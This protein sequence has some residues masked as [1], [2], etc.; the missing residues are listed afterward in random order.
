MSRKSCLP[1]ALLAA[2]IAFL[3]PLTAAPAAAQVDPA[4]FVNAFEGAMGQHK[5]FRR[6]GA[7]GVCAVGEFVGNADGRNLS[8][9]S[10]FSGRA[11]PVVLRFSVGGANPKAPDNAKSVR[12]MAVAFDLPNSET[13]QMANISTPVF[14]A[15]TPE[16]F[17]ALLES[18]AVDPQTRA[19]DPAKVKAFND[20]NPEV[21][22]QGRYLAGQPVPA[23]Y[24]MVNY[25]GVNSFVFVNDKG[26]RRHAKWVFE[27]AAGTM[28]LS[29]EEAKAKPADFL[30]DELRQRVAQGAV[31]F[32]F[33]LQLAEPGDNVT[34][35]V[36]PLPADRRKV[37]VGQLLVR[38]VEAADGGACANMTFN[39]TALP[40]GVEASADPI[41]LGRAAPYA[42]SL[43]RRLTE[44]R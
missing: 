31:A 13:W 37:T 42:V 27:P 4:R 21:L 34:S 35:A 1:S 15:A 5:G 26:E 17:V 28:G 29:D 14:G 23:S 2:Q 12:G 24:G 9:S 8:V 3:L 43:G 39:P 33:N 30:F 19:A 16:Q 7:K 38:K 32:N 25:W 22:L 20:A 44:G 40:R 11:V 6:S 18:R 36:V 41:L 10:A